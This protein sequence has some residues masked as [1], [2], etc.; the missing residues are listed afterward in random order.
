MQPE[1]LLPIGVVI[2]REDPLDRLGTA[3]IRLE[4]RF[5]RLPQLGKPPV[6]RIAPMARGPVEP[7]ERRGQFKNPG[8]RFEEVAV[9]HLHHVTRLDHERRFAIR[10]SLR[11]GI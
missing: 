8:P 6:G 1:R 3:R 7:V 9:G 5:D 2:E 11:V 4:E 10:P